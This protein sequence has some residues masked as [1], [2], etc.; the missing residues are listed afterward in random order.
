MNDTQLLREFV[1]RRSESAFAALVERHLGLVQGTARRVTGSAAVAEEVA[2]GV[3]LLLARKAPELGPE[4]V[5]SGWLHRAA[6]F[7][8]A[9]A[10]QSELR[11]RRREELAVSMQAHD[12]SP[13]PTDP[14]WAAAL[15]EL[16]AALGQLAAADRDALL[17]RYLEQRPLREVGT[18]LGLS[19]E[20][21]KKRVSRALE[22]LRRVFLR[23]GRD[24]SV[25]ALAAG[26]AAEAAAQAAMLAGPAAAAALTRDVLGAWARESGAGSAASGAGVSGGSQGEWMTWSAEGLADWQRARW[27]SALWGSVAAVGLVVMMGVGFLASSGNWRSWVGQGARA[28]VGPGAAASG[29]AG[30]GAGPEAG[31]DRAAKAG[32]A[33]SLA[34]LLEG[35]ADW[36][37]FGGQRIAVRTLWLTV[38]DE[39][40]GEPIPGADAVHSLMAPEKGRRSNALRADARGRIRVRVPERLPGAE[41]MDQF[42]VWISA[43]NRPA[44]TLN[45]LSTTGN[46]MSI[47][48]TQ[49]TVRLGTGIAL[50]G[51]VVDANGAPIM[52]VRVG[53]TGSN[54]RGYTVG[55]P[56]VRL[57]EYSSFSTD[58]DGEGPDAV[59]TDRNG[60]FRLA[61]FP[62]DLRA[63]K[64][65][66][67]T[68]DG[69]RAG[70][71][72][73]AGSWLSAEELP[74][75]EFDALE[76][77]TARFVMPRGHTV[78]GEVVTLEGE[79]IRGASVAEGIQWGNLKILHR[80][81]T[82]FFG[83][84]ALS[85]RPSREVILVAS[86]PGFA[87]VSTIVQA[88]PALA[89]VRL[90][91]PS[92]QPLRGR[93]VDRGG[94]ALPGVEVSVPDLPNAGTGLE[95]KGVTDAE[96][97]FAW[98]GAPT[99]Q[100][101]MAFSSATHGQRLVPMRAAGTEVVVTLG[102][103]AHDRIR[104]TGRVTDA[105]TGRPIERFI[106]RV[107]HDNTMP[108]GSDASVHGQGT[109]GRF[110]REVRMD[111]VAVGLMPHWAVAVTADGYEPAVSRFYLFEEGDQEVVLALEPGGTM[112]LTLRAPDG[113]PVRTA[114]FGFAAGPRPVH[115]MNA[116]RLVPTGPPLPEKSDSAG[117]FRL[118]RPVG[119]R[120]LVV[121]AENGWQT[122]PA[123]RGGERLDLN[124]Q[125]WGRVEG[126]LR[127]GGVPRA[128]AAV[129]LGQ[130]VWD[131][132]GDYLILHNATT[133]AEGRFSFPKLPAGEYVVVWSDAAWQAM[134]ERSVRSLEVPV[135]LGA[136]ETRDVDLTSSGARV[137]VRLVPPEGVTAPGATAGMAPGTVLATL[138]VDVAMPPRPARADYVSEAAYTEASRVYPQDPR[139]REA[140]RRERTYVGTVDPDGRVTFTDIPPGRYRL[141]VAWHASPAKAPVPA[142]AHGG[143]EVLGR[144]RTMVTVP[145]SAAAAAGPEGGAAVAID[146]GAVRLTR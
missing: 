141:D 1:D 109:G 60:R 85:N 94:E 58:I 113:G 102:G 125:P 144:A 121:F 38:E 128:G 7:V 63:L 20:A 114:Q 139:V 83:R 86:A 76:S 88:G 104:L 33:V 119:A 103:T 72:T 111:A 130:L 51:N 22:R 30:A 40:T 80:T 64:F 118:A 52:G 70:F 117:V 45:W 25:A 138:S 42:S 18:A 24:L 91:L 43:T 74:E 99:N 13:S 95:W 65:E 92:A 145:P 110:E 19:E 132:S 2:Q 41:R 15:P 23:R 93:V 134:G 135:M 120:S 133:D 31:E 34:G 127:P 78:A 84:F 46:V 11:R 106:Y 5:L 4:V 62:R 105:A 29:R 57:Q 123:K 35:E 61:P 50:S 44:R 39:A 107:W 77:G 37:D 54:H 3:F 56:E 136:G 8:A 122:I 47:V 32:E 100:V 90:A 28:G 129:A 26:L 137:Q 98:E 126:T 55:K 131:W 146:A 142:G 36:F 27:R 140:A 71:R 12:S 82:D 143:R 73:A 68:A 17:L 97:R 21:A 9:R 14:A 115:S 87:T 112:E 10:L 101:V 75:I 124:L 108:A 116:G 53:V 81:D 48:T 79:A 69:A 96:G 59:V 6:R 16:D 89:P 66:L 67:K 49:H